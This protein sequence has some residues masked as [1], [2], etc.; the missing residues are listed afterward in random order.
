MASRLSTFWSREVRERMVK[1]PVKIIFELKS[2]E[3]LES[4][5]KIFEKARDS[6]PDTTINAEIRVLPKIKTLFLLQCK[7]DSFRL[8]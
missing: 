7:Q 5:L 4:A 3:E 1:M 8:Q 6:H 2:M